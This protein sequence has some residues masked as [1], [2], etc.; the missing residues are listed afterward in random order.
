MNTGHRSRIR[1]N[2]LPQR[3]CGDATR[4]PSRGIVL[5]PPL[6]S[7][8]YDYHTPV[9]T[10]EVVHYLQP[11]PG[12]IYVDGTFGGG[13]HAEAILM[14]SEPGGRLI[15]LDLDSDALEQAAVRLG[16][17]G[18]RVVSM[19]V[20]FSKIR[21]SLERA[22]I[23]HVSGILLDLG[24]SSHQV[25]EP[26]RGFSFQQDARLDMRMDR[27]NPLDAWIV[28]NT[29]SEENIASLMWRYGD[30]R[31]SRR[32]AKKIVGRRAETRIDTTSELAAVIES[33]VGGRFALKSV[34]RVFQA[35]RIE[36][37]GELDNLTDALNDSIDLLEIGGRIVVLSYHSL[38]DRIVK[39]FIRS[40]SQR[41]I[42][43]KHHLVPDK[44]IQPRLTPLTK[45]PV[46]AGDEECRQ[47]PRARSAKLRAAE[48]IS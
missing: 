16:R 37:N 2:R 47:N 41:L 26:S 42:K 35:I 15:G 7:M 29:Y 19:Q 34:A 10:R 4:G 33:A 44:P 17:F 8:M 40:E 12:G 38:E 21:S 46:E 20:N 24:I 23:Q 6:Q 11:H 5:D 25:D 14:A 43:S 39:N 48:R 32:I 36:V 1:T 3:L 28:V 27:T 13:G 45:K 9:L 18:D 31:L 30:E 22:G